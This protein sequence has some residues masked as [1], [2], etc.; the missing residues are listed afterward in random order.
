[1]RLDAKRDR[2]LARRRGLAKRTI[3]A[4]IWLAICFALAFLIMSYL[5]DN[6]LLSYNF[7]YSRLFIPSEV[8]ETALLIASMVVIV[9]I[10]NFFVLLGYG[11]A[12]PAGRRRPGTPS[13][14]SGEPDPDDQNFDYR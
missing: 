11:L 5:F 2:E 3:L 4:V 6:D 1:M 7:F 12:S 8:S 13:M 9:I 14:H 10:I